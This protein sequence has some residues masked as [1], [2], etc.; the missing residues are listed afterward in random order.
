M[1]GA[2]TAGVALGA[3]V[4]VA[5][6]GAARPKVPDEVKAR[7]LTV[8]D[9]AGGPALQLSVDPEGNPTIALAHKAGSA[10]IALKMTK[11][12]VPSLVFLGGTAS[13]TPSG[14]RIADSAGTT[15]ATLE[16][17]D[18]G[19]TAL[20][21]FDHSQQPAVRVRVPAEGPAA[22]EALDRTGARMIA[23]G[24]EDGGARITLT[25]IRG[26][27][28]LGVLADGS[29]SL[30]I[31]QDGK[32]RAGLSAASDG[33]VRLSLNDRNGRSRA[34]ITVQPGG[35]TEVLPGSRSRGPEQ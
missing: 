33:P 31:D 1:K 15:R 13:I 24:E 17:A 21:L 14:L 34:S 22:I 20:V 12:G 32:S 30:S 16:T 6:L 19:T 18:D 9:Q 27:A 7:R 5:L 3:V 25:G 23:I 35:A 28:E 8:V 4:L 11:E 26:H 10:D 29:A 2:M